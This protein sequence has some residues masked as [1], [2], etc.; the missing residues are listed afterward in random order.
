MP[1]AK[2][3]VLFV[4]VDQWPGDLLG[5][6]GHGTIETPTI[7]QLARV[8]TRYTNCYA[9]TP[10]CIPARRS[11]MTGMS[12]RGHGDRD[13]QPDLP[14]P[15]DAPTLAGTF[16]AAGYQTFATGKLH[17]Y[18]PRDRI[19]FDDAQLAEEGRGHLGGPDDYEMFLADCGYP[20]EQFMHGM[21][22]NE[23]SW[24]TWH[25]PERTHVTNWTASTAARTIKRRDPTR[26]SFWHVSFTHPHPPLVPLDSYL[27]RY[28]RREMPPPVGGDW[29]ARA[30]DLPFVV[31]ATR[32]YYATLTPEQL[33]DMRRAFYALCTHI[34]HQLRLII[35]TLREE[36]ILDDTIIVFASDHGDMLGDH[37]LYGKR[38][39]YDNSA[40][41]PLIVV[42]RAGRQR[43]GPMGGTDDRLATLHDLMPTMLDMAGIEGPATCEGLS[44]AGGDRRAHLY[45]ESHL[46]ARASR[47]VRDERF[48]L[49]WYPAGN[50]MQLFDLERDPA[51][52]EDL[53]GN[54]SF[55]ERRRHLEAVLIDQLY[56]ED[57]DLIVG[58]RLVGLPEPEMPRI[59]NRGL[60]GQRGVHFP[61][62]PMADPGTKV[63]AW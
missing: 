36:G 22:N 53:S 60:S 30:E 38:L 54:D 62:V 28:T 55:A 57:L 7:D 5:C 49:I 52:Q 10:I 44:L 17:V 33:A 47:M 56:G 15:A 61:E 48:K 3:N 43:C 37:G 6:A 13:F 16:G 4:T 1:S 12:S 46:G 14:M 27:E 59:D 18:P 40:R 21:S 32:N 20:G 50:R 19:G 2:P 31:R 8:G 25:L 51:E 45:G 11:I 9:Q 58:D 26:P 63:G 42:D 23:Y 34:D 41:V 35:G 29:S 24:R 39:L